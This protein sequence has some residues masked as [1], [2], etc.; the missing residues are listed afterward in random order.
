VV[1]WGVLEGGERDKA[2]QASITFPFKGLKARTGVWCVLMAMMFL[3][4][5]HDKFLGG[6]ELLSW[7]GVGQVYTRDGVPRSE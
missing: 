3:F 6:V 1:S 5:G 4:S 2:R 7:W